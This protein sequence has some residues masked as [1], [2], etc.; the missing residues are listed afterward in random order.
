MLEGAASGAWE[1]LGLPGL[2]ANFGPR[3]AVLRSRTPNRP[4]SASWCPP[5][6]K[7]AGNAARQ[8]LRE[9]AGQE[10]GRREGTARGAGRGAGGR[11]R[12]R[13]M[14]APRGPATVMPPTLT[15][16]RVLWDAGS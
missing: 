4:A 11:G 13:R 14:E 2:L 15:R 5:G 10:A 16:P 7:C 8:Q 12:W 6:C 1:L 9:V 3:A